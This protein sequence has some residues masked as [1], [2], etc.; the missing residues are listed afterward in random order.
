MLT[1]ETDVA[2]PLWPAADWQA[3]AAARLALRD[4]RFT[5]VE[6]PY[7]YGSVGSIQVA[8]VTRHGSVVAAVQAFQSTPA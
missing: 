4:D 7:F 1:T 5:Y 8:A 3:L 2:S 6:V